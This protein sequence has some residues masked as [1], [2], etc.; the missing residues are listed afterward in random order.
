MNKIVKI[1]RFQQSYINNYIFS[2]KN[3]I[4]LPLNILFQSFLDWAN[5]LD[6]N[7]KYNQVVV[8][9][10]ANGHNYIAS[11]SDNEIQIKL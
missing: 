11:H 2:K 7:V 6:N 3:H 1:P 5:N 4:A 8:N 10:Y 9:W